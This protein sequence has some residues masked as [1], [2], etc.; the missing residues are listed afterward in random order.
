MLAILAA[1]M[2][3]AAPQH[4]TVFTADGGRILGTVIEESPQTVAIQTPDGTVRRLPRRDVVRIEY[5][6]GSVS[7]RT[8]EQA[9]A[10][11]APSAPPP[12]PPS[13]P[14]PPPGYAPPPPPAYYPPPYYGR[15]RPPPTYAPPNPGPIS[16]LWGSFSLGGM[17]FGGDVSR[18]VGVSRIFGP[19]MDIG[20]EGGLRLNPHL[21]LG[22]YLD[23]G[24]G[25][26][27]SEVNAFCN[28]DPT[29]PGGGLGGADCSAQ[30][31][32]FGILARHTF[33]P[34][35][36]VTPW[37]SIGT[38]Y[39]YGNVSTDAFGGST[40]VVTYTGWEIARLMAGVDV[41]SN[42][43]LGVGFYAGV[44][45]TRYTHAENTAGTFPL[46]GTTVHSMVQAGIRLTL[47]P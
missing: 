5:A 22:L 42:Q 37:V 32:K 7:H 44:S 8:G 14:P 27:G 24:V 4:D 25:G 39:A 10:Q 17:F 19:Q 43:V 15:P 28:A 3:A 16:P 26:P 33:A 12:A 38:G 29:S 11:A 34:S 18:G 21:G 13:T 40:D 20:L 9:P 1:V 41:R 2:L 35:A 31:V 36:R 6:D 47:F 45:L 46:D 23:I 30:T